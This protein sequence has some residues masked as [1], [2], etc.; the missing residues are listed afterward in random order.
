MSQIMEPA[1][2]GEHPVKAFSCCL[3]FPFCELSSSSSLQ[4]QQSL[5]VWQTEVIILP[6]AFSLKGTLL[7]SNWPSA[8]LGDSLLHLLMF[9][10]RRR[11]KVW[12]LASFRVPPVRSRRWSITRRDAGATLSRGVYYVIQARL[13]CVKR[14]CVCVAH[15]PRSP[16]LCGG[17]G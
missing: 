6:N 16:C 11:R 13:R 14:A 17:T 4:P 2:R 7:Q 8:S 10:R 1:Q 12:P 3:Y 15:F 5:K 9:W